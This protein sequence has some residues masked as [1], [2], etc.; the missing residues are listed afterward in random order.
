MMPY[1]KQRTGKECTK[2]AC[3]RHKDY[4]AWNCGNS[5]L[6]FCME[7]KHAHVSQYKKQG[8]GNNE[9]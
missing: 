6:K 7:C 2:I 4:L 8:G 3:T 9:A 5:S 1:P